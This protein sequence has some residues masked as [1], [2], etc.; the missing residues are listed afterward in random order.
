MLCV[1][2]VRCR[3]CGHY[4]R[5]AN[6]AEVRERVSKEGAIQLM[7][8]AKFLCDALAAGASPP[9]AADPDLAK[10]VLAESA[11]SNSATGGDLAEP[12]AIKDR[13][14]AIHNQLQT[15]VRTRHTRHR[16]RRT[17]PHARHAR[18][19]SCCVFGGFQLDPIDRAFYG[20]HVNRMEQQCYAR[21]A[22]LLGPLVSLHPLYTDVYAHDAHDTHDT[23]DTRHTRHTH[24]THQYQLV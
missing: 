5:L 3:V 20:P 7:F 21:S 1:R 4:W 15:L 6:A 9:H 14:K 22:A 8:D 10:A 11:T 16:T 24:D 2:R 17:R 13:I 19:S 12:S 18:S 23:H